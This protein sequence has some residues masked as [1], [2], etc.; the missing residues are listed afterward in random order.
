MPLFTVAETQ[1]YLVN[2]RG[3]S[4]LSNTDIVDIHRKCEGLPL[5]LRYVA[6]VIMSSE[7]IQ[8]Q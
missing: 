6:E 7:T 4:D 1:D 3:I 5:Y 2:K 8:M